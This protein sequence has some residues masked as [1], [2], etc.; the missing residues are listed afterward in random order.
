MTDEEARDRFAAAPIARLATADGRGRPHIVPITFAVR[1]ETVVTVVDRKPKR[2][3]NLKRLRNIVEN[4]RVSV[5]VDHYEDDWGALW[6]V[7]ADGTAGVVE[8]ESG[9]ADALPVL[10]DKYPQYRG[11]VPEGPLIVIAVDRWA[12]WSG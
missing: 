9:I 12:S 3:R 6:W 8:E 1:G 10:Q 7:R 2:S 4:P 5:L 11:D